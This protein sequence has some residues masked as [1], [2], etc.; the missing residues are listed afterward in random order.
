M[1]H[2]TIAVTQ[3]HFED[4]LIV[5]D[6]PLYCDALMSAVQR[7][8]QDAQCR[9]ARTLREA[10]EVLDRGFQPQLVM[11][12]LK[13][14]DVS[15]ISGFLNLRA[16][17]PDTPILV[18]SSLAT[19]DLVHALMDEGAAGFMPKDSSANDLKHVLLEVAS[20]RKYVPGDF[21]QMRTPQ[22]SLPE[23]MSPELAALTPQQKKVMKLICAGKPNK[24]IAYE[25]D[26]AEA[27]VKAH[28]T[29]LLRRLGVKNR[30]QA[31]VLIEA[32]MTNPANGLGDAEPEAASFLAR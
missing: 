31:A 16:R 22:R 6:H 1:Q 32:A 25:L 12:D 27:T 13:L 10:L 11:F 8:F 30:T 24:Q 19:V 14:P 21:Q 9:K 23:D 28:I 15:G 3:G 17:L 7:V 18:I 20:G 2:S 4:V 5:D 26:L 29:A